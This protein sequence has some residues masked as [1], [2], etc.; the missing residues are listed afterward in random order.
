VNITL[1]SQGT[2][3]EVAVP[4]LQGGSGTLS[5]E[6]L[7]ASQAAVDAA[8]RAEAAAVDV[9][10]ALS[11]GFPRRRV[12]EEIVA[13]YI[14]GTR[15]L[16]TDDAAPEG[17]EKR[18]VLAESWGR[19]GVLREIWLTVNSDGKSNNL[20]NFPHWGSEL[21]V[22]TDDAIE[23]VVAMPIGDFFMYSPADGSFQSLRVGRTG[24]DSNNSAGYRYLWAPFREYLRVEV[25]NW[26]PDTVACDLSGVAIYSLVD[27]FAA[28]GQE[29]T[30]LHVETAHE[31]AFPFRTPLTIC[32]FDGE[33]Q[34]ESI[35]V[36]INDAAEAAWPIDSG[37]VMVYVDG[38]EHPAYVS[39]STNGFADGSFWGALTDG[40][41]GGAGGYEDHAITRFKFFDSTP[42]FFTSHLRVVW[43]TGRPDVYSEDPGTP[44]PAVDVRGTVTC[45]MAG[46]R[47][48][49]YA[50]V[51]QDAA[52][53]YAKPTPADGPIPAYLTP[54]GDSWTVTGGL[55]TQPVI[56]GSRTLRLNDI[57]LGGDFWV[58]TTARITDPDHR[59]QEA[60]IM[61][62]GTTGDDLG[63]A[64]RLILAHGGNSR[65]W[66]IRA[67]DGWSLINNRVINHGADL[68]GVPVDLAV[69][70]LG[71]DVTVYW[72]L[73]G[74]ATWQPVAAWQSTIPQIRYAKIATLN[75]AAAFT[76]PVIRPI[77]K[78][79]NW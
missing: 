1:T 10:T 19:P 18:L 21:R 56:E 20:A 38:S 28:F 67:A 48:P 34:V 64:T 79:D 74:A 69:R 14:S 58:E 6:G 9:S 71:R 4:G 73:H 70:V 76:V 40:L 26:Q 75:A 24:N 49:R 30:Q 22:F 53:I 17:V 23:P 11:S 55:L 63:E 78:T 33:G 65:A 42:L 68:T 45:L 43:W 61:L 12:G 66:W 47:E 25:V 46:S 72:R 77:H 60:S 39:E 54:V 57:E 44:G 29:Q 5:P 62:C 8:G 16:T 41:H 13:Q 7:A 3:V 31:P 51:D 35:H 32:D 59:D 52:P 37:P 15:A 36:R 27:D 50:A 2:A